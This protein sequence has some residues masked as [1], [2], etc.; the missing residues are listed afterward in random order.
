MISG[1]ASAYCEAM[2]TTERSALKAGRGIGLAAFKINFLRF[3]SNL[4]VGKPCEVRRPAIAQQ[5]IYHDAQE[6]P[7]ME[8]PSFRAEWEDYLEQDFSR[9]RNPAGSYQVMPRST[10]SAPSVPELVS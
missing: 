8:L 1:I 6:I 10:A 4:N 2:I 5:K 7:A 3:S 9:L